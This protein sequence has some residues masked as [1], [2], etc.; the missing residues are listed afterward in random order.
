MF[1]RLMA[2]CPFQVPFEDAGEREAYVSVMLSE[3]ASLV[4]V[5]EE[6]VVGWLKAASDGCCS[7]YDCG[8]RVVERK[9][10]EIVDPPW[11][12]DGWSEGQMVDYMLEE[13][14]GVIENWGQSH[15]VVS[16][17]RCM[18][19]FSNVEMIDG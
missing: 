11:E 12:E 10:R 17:D 14:S 6:V 9:R 19:V 15:V 2:E 13:A 18:R 1:E 8:G 7:V 16:C 4:E 3:T 5:A